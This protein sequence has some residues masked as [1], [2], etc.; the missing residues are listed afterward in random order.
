VRSWIAVLSAGVVGSIAV[1]AVGPDARPIVALV[2]FVAALITVWHRTLRLPPK[3]RHAFIYFCAAGTVSL[4]GAI[5][6]FGHGQITGAVDPLPSPADALFMVGYALFIVGGL[7]FYRYRVR[8]PEQNG[9]L[10]AFILAAAIGSLVWDVLLVPYLRDPEILL[11]G[12]ITN[13]IYSILTLSLVAI[14]VRII[15]SPGRRATSYYLFGAAVSCFFLTDLLST[16]QY[17]RNWQGDF[18][19]MMTLPVYALFG[20]AVYHPTAGELT[21]PLPDVEPTM[22][23][24]RIAGLAAALVIPPIL[25]VRQ[26]RLA[27][28]REFV[29]IIVGSS[30]VMAVLVTY[31]L[32]RLVM[33]REQM[34][35]HAQSLQSVGAHLV[36]ATSAEEIH[37]RVLEAAL[38]VDSKAITGATL[39]T[40]NEAA[41]QFEVALSRGGAPTDWRLVTALNAQVHPDGE[42]REGWTAGLHLLRL[43][44]E[45]RSLL[46]VQ[47][48][49]DLDRFQ[50]RYLATLGR[51]AA[52]AHR[53]NQARD[54]LAEERGRRRLDAL[55]Q[56]SGDLVL[57]AEDPTLP[58]EYIS[59][60]A[61][62]L[63]GCESEDAELPTL[64]KL[65]H[66][67]DRATFLAQCEALGSGSHTPSQDLRLSLGD[68]TWRWFDVVAT[69]LHE[70]PEIHGLVINARDASDRRAAQQSV[71][72]SEARFRALVQ[73]SADIVAVID[74]GTIKY[75]SPS[76]QRVLGYDPEDLI[77]TEVAT[78][79][80]AEDLRPLTEALKSLQPQSVVVT[81]F[82]IRTSAGDTLTMEALLTDL[83]GEPAV[84]GVVVN[85]RDISVPRELESKLRQA[86][87]Y[88]PLTGLPNRAMLEDAA[89][90]SAYSSRGKPHHIAVLF[91]DLDDFKDVNDGF[92]REAGDAVLRTVASR[93]QEHT[94]VRD[95]AVRIGGDEFAVLVSECYG[96]FELEELSTRLLS[97]LAVPMIIG[98]QSISISAS[99]GIASARGSRNDTDDLLRDADAAMYLAKERGKGRAEIFR[100]SLRREA[101][102]RV[103]LTNDMRMGLEKDEFFLVY[104][105]IV[106]L[107][108]PE[109]VGV[110]AL[111]RW[112]HPT[113]GLL[114]PGVFISLAEQTGLILQL[115]RHVLRTACE[116]LALWSAVSGPLSELTLSVNLSTHQMRDPEIVIYLRRLITEFSIEPSRLTLEVTESVLAHDPA[117]MLSRLQ[118]MKELGISLAIDDF[119]TG[120]S[121]LSYLQTYPFDVLK[122]D[123]AFVMQLDSGSDAERAVVRTIVELA[124]QLG[125]DTVAEGIETQSAYDAV[126]GMG[127]PKGQG[128]FFSKPC[129]IETLES[130]VLD[131]NG[132]FVQA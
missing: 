108:G 120:Y 12:R 73:N 55:V 62:S 35:V 109:V 94:R 87:Y 122:I 76:V 129:T 37:H 77:G 45:P 6:R 23:V 43:D 88:D 20:A 97:A 61:R 63:L 105:P 90:A 17:A 107:D 32:Y 72:E 65:L 39:F 67:D 18:G 126:R 125:A 16:L 38:S 130:S 93:L 4:A 56:N 132:A 101:A 85:A 114:M 58:F 128:Y 115:G 48:T 54:Q 96:D 15:S 91:I 21:E 112:N 31:R 74:S 36:A 30:F 95:L 60:A 69:N 51:S 131:I 47:T 75:A 68:G 127:C 29:P 3:A 84:Q 28:D 44:T 119:G 7:R 118:E 25:M 124:E 117:V 102:E 98:E 22:S 2:L 121:S 113:R 86:A 5:V 9:W 50:R 78:H 33:D 103:E 52:L 10:D 49:A 8:E 41:D 80:L 104:Q 42:T 59:P 24:N 89:T 116:Q 13:A 64:A 70:H 11:A 46:L 34:T 99:I 123:R 66:V 83:R 57:V 14:S 92:G 82:R 40:W 27:D 26:L 100:E 71:L 106:A 19:L 1:V 81:E 110:E 53:S 79:V 111:A